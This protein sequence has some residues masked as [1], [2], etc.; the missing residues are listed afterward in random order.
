MLRWM[1]NFKKAVLEISQG[2]TLCIWSGINLQEKEKHKYE[3][4]NVA[5][6]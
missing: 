6:N 5:N 3:A 4:E 1:Q 2:E